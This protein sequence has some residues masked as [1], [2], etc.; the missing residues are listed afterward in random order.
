MELQISHSLCAKIQKANFL[1][2]AQSRSG[3]NIKGIVRM[4]R[5]NDNRGGSVPKS[6]THAG[7]NTTKRKCIRIHGIFEGKKQY[8][9]TRK[10]WK[11]KV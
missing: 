4:E 9:D 2:R 8:I 6:H 1:W 11:F 3:E 7:R 5:D 10:T